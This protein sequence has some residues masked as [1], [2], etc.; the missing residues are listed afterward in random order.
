MVDDGGVCPIVV[1]DSPKITLAP[2]DQR[3]VHDGV[4][5]FFCKASGN[6]APDVY[7]RKAGRRI[8]TGRQ[9]YVVVDMPHGAV[10]RVEP[11]KSRRDD[12]VV[13]CVADNGVGEPAVASAKLDVYPEHRSTYAAR[14]TGPT[15]AI[16][17]S[18]SSYR[19]RFTSH[20]GRCGGADLYCS[21]EADTG[22]RYKTTDM[23]LTHRVVCPF[24]V[25]LSPVLSYTLW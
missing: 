16:G 7:W 22:L 3:V 12:S 23:G 21:R 4:A 6:P 15:G 25:Q 19:S 2:R 11:V 24:S 9:R 5:S 20:V 18:A 1:A 13:E 14:C 10:L 17:L 8:T